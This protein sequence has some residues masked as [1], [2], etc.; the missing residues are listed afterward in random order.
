MAIKQIKETFEKSQTIKVGAQKVDPRG[1]AIPGVTALAVKDLVPMQQAELLK[2]SMVVN[3]DELDKTVMNAASLNNG[4]LLYSFM[5]K[6]GEPRQSFYSLQAE[7][8]LPD[9][10]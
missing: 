7:E 6:N 9:E 2:L 8:K 4:H 5:D 1:K 3:V 10:V